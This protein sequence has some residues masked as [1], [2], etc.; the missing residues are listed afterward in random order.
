MLSA[1]LVSATLAFG[2]QSLILDLSMSMAGFATPQDNRIP[3]VLQRLSVLLEPG[4]SLHVYGLSGPGGGVLTPYPWQQAAALYSSSHS[5]RGS[6]PL[7]HGIDEAVAHRRGTDLIVMTD[8]MEDDGNLDRLADSIEGLVGRNWGVGLIA[9]VFPFDGT[10][11]TEQ[12][13]TDAMLPEIQKS[14]HGKNVAWNVQRDKPT[15]CKPGEC[16]AFRGERPM[17]FLCLSSSGSATRL[18]NLVGQA[19]LESSVTAVGKVDLAPFRPP[20]LSVVVDAPAA[21]RSRIKLPNG[22]GQDLMC[23]EPIRDRMDMSLHASSTTPTSQP[24][25]L[26]P[27]DPQILERPN[28]IIQTPRADPK[29][30]GVHNFQV[31]CPKGSITERVSLA[32]G[33][34]RVRYTPIFEVAG[35]GWWNEWSAENSWQFPFKVYKLLPLVRAIHGKA[36]AGYTAPP[37]DFTLRMR[38]QN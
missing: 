16:Y 18:L 10:Y 19:L 30:P 12:T 11:Y 33:S 7:S 35:P 28:W 3:G 5:F 29:L 22:V 14:V 23:A 8:G 21:T 20:S 32:P 17:I 34:L 25:V 4:G 38:V 37:V 13:I 1:A 31:V 24:S 6:T 9:V 36:V 15:A 2:E 27:S 26:R